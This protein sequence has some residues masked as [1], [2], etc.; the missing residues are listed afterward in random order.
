MRQLTVPLHNW[1]Q[2]AANIFN[3]IVK[4]VDDIIEA[5]NELNLA[6]FGD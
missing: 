3:W 1:K 2:R 4:F 6:H 5:L